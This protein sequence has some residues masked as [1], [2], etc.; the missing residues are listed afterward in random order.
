M[1]LLWLSCGLGDCLGER[2]KQVALLNF[3]AGH[4]GV[5][6]KCRHFYLLQKGAES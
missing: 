5:D 2:G 4:V 6:D 3:V 1:Y